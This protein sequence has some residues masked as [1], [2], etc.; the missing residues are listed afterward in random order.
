LFPNQQR[1]DRRILDQ[2]SAGK[3][4]GVSADAVQPLEAGG[5]DPAWSTGHNAGSEFKGGADAKGET[6]PPSRRLHGCGE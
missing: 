5:L 3:P 6:A 1:K 4:T 2:V